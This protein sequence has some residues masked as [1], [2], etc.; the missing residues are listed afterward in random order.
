MCPR[1][2]VSC[3]V[4]LLPQLLLPQAFMQGPTQ[5][6]AGAEG[7]ILDSLLGTGQGLLWV[8]QQ[9]ARHTHL[10]TD[11]LRASGQA[12]THIIAHLSQIPGPAL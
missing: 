4:G 2:H 12:L 7:G 6:E 10:S 11:G 5:E 3:P 9:Q 1:S 8:G